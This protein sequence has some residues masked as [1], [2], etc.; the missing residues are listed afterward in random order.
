MI[1]HDIPSNSGLCDTKLLHNDASDFDLKYRN[2][3]GRWV[4]NNRPAM[5]FEKNWLASQQRMAA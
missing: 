3:S 5:V 4:Q 1:L 2:H